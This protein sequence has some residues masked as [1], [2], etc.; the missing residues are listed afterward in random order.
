M[1]EVLRGLAIAVP[2]VVFVA[3][4]RLAKGLSRSGLQ[5]VKRSTVVEVRRRSDGGF[6]T[7][8][9]SGGGFPSTEERLEA[10]VEASAAAKGAGEPK[11]GV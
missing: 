6:A 7:E 11:V 9:E 4:Y 2:I 1:V 10:D 5:P 8:E 3:A